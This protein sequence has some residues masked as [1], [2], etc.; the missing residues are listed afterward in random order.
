M[1]VSPRSRS[2]ES[3]RICSDS[4]PSRG[5]CR[6]SRSSLFW[7]GR[8]KFWNWREREREGRTKFSD[9]E[10]ESFPSKESCYESD[11]T[12]KLIALSEA[13]SPALEIYLEGIENETGRLWI[14]HETGLFSKSL[15]VN[16]LAG[17]TSAPRRSRVN[18][19]ILTS[20]WNRI[21]NDHLYNEFLPPPSSKNT[22]KERV[23]ILKAKFINRSRWKD[24]LHFFVFVVF[25]YTKNYKIFGFWFF[26]PSEI[27]QSVF[28][29][30]YK[31]NSMLYQWLNYYSQ[32]NYSNVFLNF[33]SWGY[34]ILKESTKISRAL[35]RWRTF[36]KYL[37]DK[38]L[39]CLKSILS[40]L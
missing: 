4:F 20:R 21:I 33:S 11:E 6:E 38:D 12:W 35:L 14:L 24:I 37:F 23:R 17:T 9:I 2:V 13:N 32:L 3:R 26:L 29:F 19:T 40:F 34:S 22:G 8:G 16:P 5:A 15:K 27:F 25:W 18:F 30:N 1:V 10:D 28:F 7:R 39:I 31:L 36:E